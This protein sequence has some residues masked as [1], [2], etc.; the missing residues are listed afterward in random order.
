[1]NLVIA[2]KQLA[3]CNPNNLPG[4]L[5]DDNV[6][7]MT[8]YQNMQKELVNAFTQMERER[9]KAALAFTLL[10]R[11]CVSQFGIPE[12]N[13]KFF[14]VKEAN[15]EGRMHH[16]DPLQVIDRDERGKWTAGMEIKV[17]PEEAY[18]YATTI[19]YPYVGFNASSMEIRLE[20]D[21]VTATVT[22]TGDNPSFGP[23]LEKIAEDIS[24]TA[25]W[26]RHGIGERPP[27]GFGA[28]QQKN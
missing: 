12:E 4:G 17:D 13:I 14:A 18:S 21:L 15:D 5:V 6:V 1:V 7:F 2:R 25:E 19:L 28:I 8:S 16:R 23:M 24:A 26:V 10:A 3:R 11:A 22:E 27:I 9:R 20:N